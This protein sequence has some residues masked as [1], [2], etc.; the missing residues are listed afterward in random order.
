MIAS[1][2]ARKDLSV[3]DVGCATGAQLAALRDEGF[4]EL[5]GLDPSPAC[6]LAARD[7]YGIDVV[8]GLAADIPKLEKK[9]GLVLLCAVLE[10]LHDPVQAMRDVAG[11][12]VADG[13]VFIE[14][15]DATQFAA[16]VDAPFQQFST[17]HISFFSPRSLAELLG[18]AG[19]TVHSV[20]Q[21]VHDWS[22]GTRGPAIQALFRKGRTAEVEGVDETTRVALA[23]Y[24]EA[25]AVID[26]KVRARLH[27]FAVARKPLL[28]WGT[29]AHTLRLLRSGAMDGLDIVAFVDSDPNYQGR[30]LAGRHILAPSKLAGRPEA[31]L[32][33]SSTVHH[34]IARQIRDDLL[35]GNEIV[36]LYD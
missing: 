25:S 5:E 2:V 9:Y 33:S 27:E 29:G 3:L 17:E 35:L 1:H 24:I 8:T 31:I 32:V 6:A 18:R 13:M 7:A 16:C 15:P 11:V 22:S 30:E 36:L 10:H 28:V 4:S 19:F 34:E 14:V 12:L 23:E 20:E 21:V 26:A